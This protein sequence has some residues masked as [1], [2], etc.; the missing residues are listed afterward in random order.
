MCG[1]PD[2]RVPVRVTRD[3]RTRQRSCL[4]THAHTRQRA[5]PRQRAARTAR[6]NAARGRMRMRRRLPTPSPTENLKSLIANVIILYSINDCT[7]FHVIVCTSKSDADPR[8]QIR[9]V[10]RFLLSGYG[11]Y[12]LSMPLVHTILLNKERSVRSDIVLRHRHTAA[13]L[14]ACK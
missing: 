13:Q 6:V 8:L 12:T 2:S 10:F 14:T 4:S 7:S 1:D 9:S 3:R 5:H 11:I